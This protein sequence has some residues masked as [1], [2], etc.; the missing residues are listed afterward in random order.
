MFCLT[1]P[2]VSLDKVN[3]MI[4]KVELSVQKY[5]KRCTASCL[6]E[7][8]Y[9]YCLVNSHEVHYLLSWRR[10]GRAV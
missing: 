6:H 3:L 10:E 8:N 1:L 5:T 7:F 2:Q 9:I 4:C